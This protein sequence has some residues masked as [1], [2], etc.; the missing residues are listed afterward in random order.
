MLRGFVSDSDFKTPQTGL[1]I[2]NTDIKVLKGAATAYV[3]K[4][5][6]G[7]TTLINGDY[8][9]TM[10]ATDT[11]TLG[12]G[13]VGVKVA[14]ALYVWED[15]TV[16]TTEEYDALFSNTGPL[17][18][19]GVFARGTA[20]AATSTTVQYAAS[21][22]F[23]NGAPQGMTSAIFFNGNW[24]SRQNNS[25]VGSTDTATVDAFSETPSGTPNYIVFGTAPI[26]S[27]A[28]VSTNITAVG[29]NATAANALR[30]AFIGAGGVTFTVTVNGNVLGSIGSLGVQARADVQA[31]SA[32]A[33]QAAGY[34]VARAGYLDNLNSTLDVNVIEVDGIPIQ[35]NGS[36]TQ[37]MGGP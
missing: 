32:A 9:C 7:A 25:Y 36:G 8:Y 6:G 24:Q 5:S 13:N 10:D 2:A 18:T 16:I 31:Q 22:T 11:N 20:Q 29:G 21:E 19:R 1:T 37:N 35:Q 14:T 30:D 33:L 15:F 12:C 28:S 23:Q 27:T 34:T 17:P 3:N 26:S 4:T